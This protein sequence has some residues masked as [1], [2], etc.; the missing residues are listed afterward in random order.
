MYSEKR[1]NLCVYGRS[2]GRV[3]F[4]LCISPFFLVIIISKHGQMMT[5]ERASFKD[6]LAVVLVCIQRASVVCVQ[7]T[8]GM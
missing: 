3:S 6:I 7:Y 5:N 4:F 1:W 2:Y 8:K